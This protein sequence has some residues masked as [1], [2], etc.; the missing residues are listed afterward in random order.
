MADTILDLNSKGYYFY[1]ST[2][3]V[4]LIF[5]ISDNIGNHMAVNLSPFIIS[6][7]TFP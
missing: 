5:R 3:I 1:F 7:S 2:N 6:V 4:T